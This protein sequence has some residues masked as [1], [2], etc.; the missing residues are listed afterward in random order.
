MSKVTFRLAPTGS[1]QLVKEKL[2]VCLRHVGI[3]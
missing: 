3:C 2:L 1:W